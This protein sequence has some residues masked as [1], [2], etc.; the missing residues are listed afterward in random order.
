MDLPVFL[1]AAFADGRVRMPLVGSDGESLAFSDEDLDE[2]ARVLSELETAERLE[3]PF[4]APMFS[5]AAAQWAARM[6]YRACQFAVD[7]DASADVVARILG[8]PCPLGACP[9][10][11]YSIDLT[12]RF[13]TDV[14]RHVKNM[15][16]DDPVAAALGHWATAWPFSSVGMNVATSV[17]LDV[18][19]SHAGLR[20]R[21]AD[22]VILAGDNVRAEH[23]ATRTAIEEAVGGHDALAATLAPRRSTAA[24]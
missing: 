13:L 17:N 24:S 3:F 9:D 8:E 14:Q 12:F 19:L 10:S 20:R 11:I 16:Q 5:P 18:V 4:E 21:Y 2:A 6:L 7:R 1:R 23:E 22:R 15:P